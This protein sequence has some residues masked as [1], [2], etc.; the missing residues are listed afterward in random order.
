MNE[1][2]T[3]SVGHL[4]VL[5]VHS[6]RDS[7]DCSLSAALHEMTGDKRFEFTEVTGITRARECLLE[8]EFDIVILDCYNNFEE[9]RNAIEYLQAGF[10]FLPLAFISPDGD[11]GNAL[12]LI[13]AGSQ[14]VLL[15]EPLKLS[16][17]IPNRSLGYF[18]YAC[19]IRK[20]FE[21]RLIK[22]VQR[23]S[24]T[25]LKNRHY[26]YE[27]LKV[28]VE[29]SERYGENLALLFLDLDR[30]KVINDALGHD[31]GDNL[32]REVAQRLEATVRKIDHVARLAGDEFVVILERIENSSY[33]GAIAE[34]IIHSMAK[35]FFID[36]NEIY[37]TVSIGVSFY[38]KNDTS[39][40][41]V[42]NLIKSADIAMYRAKERGRN[43]Y[44]F[45]A[46][47]LNSQDYAKNLLKSSIENA[48]QKKQLNLHYQPVINM[49]T[50]SINSVEALLRWNHPDAGLVFPSHFLH[51]L[52]ENGLI[53]PVGE[54]VLREACRQRLFW[55]QEKLLPEHCPVSV[56]LSTRQFVG[57]NITKKVME[58]L[59]E[60][61]LPSHLLE[62]EIT[63][64]TLMDNAEVSRDMLNELHNMGIR[65][66]I[67]D[68]GVGYS[69]LRCLHDFPINSLK[70]DRSF[71]ESMSEQHRAASITYAAISMA[72]ALDIDVVA[73]GVDQQEKFD[74]L[75]QQG[76]DYFQG[77][78]F[79]QPLSA[80]GL[81]QMLDN[82]AASAS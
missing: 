67:D 23:D 54:W 40:D 82:Q 43:N 65:I 29:R 64:S 37:I 63:E 76:C 42:D 8:E 2:Q 55:M 4:S 17:N 60:T 19:V 39:T 13:A 22:Q 72:H 49:A 16:K 46:D 73:K 6:C 36:G 66:S 71:I 30:F 53:L 15:P 28:S 80:F 58:V 32:L 44:Q 68:F 79:S 59:W 41:A 62:L 12:E 20:M 27:T 14:D 25:G 56:N 11:E 5:C 10:P 9:N 21:Q 81:K 34:K 7:N 78:Y 24:L 61:Q 52:E 57:S 1:F 69:S 70:M 26:F 50:G 74:V 45:Y 3:V 31:V 75:L 48:L 77:N 35:P 18:L 38:N 51:L 33:V 47:D